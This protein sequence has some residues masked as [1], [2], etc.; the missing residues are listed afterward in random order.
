MHTLEKKTNGNT[1]QKKQHKNK[2]RKHVLDIMCSPKRKQKHT[3]HTHCR[4]AKKETRD[5]HRFQTSL[6]QPHMC[7]STKNVHTICSDVLIEATYSNIAF[8]FCFDQCLGVALF[9]K[10]CCVP[11]K[12][13]RSRCVHVL[14]F[15]ECVCVCVLVLRFVVVVF[16]CCFLFDQW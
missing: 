6:F 2:H 4:F 1:F 10:R 5:K 14:L 16:S 7:F 8:L 13:C 11:S 12:N 9:Q 15:V 3:K